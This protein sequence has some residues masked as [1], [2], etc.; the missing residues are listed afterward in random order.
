MPPFT[1]NWTMPP[2][3]CSSRCNMFPSASFPVLLDFYRSGAWNQPKQPS[4]KRRKRPSS[5]SFLMNFANDYA[6]NAR[7]SLRYALR[8]FQHKIDGCSTVFVHGCPIADALFSIILRL[9]FYAST[10]FLNILCQHYACTLSMQI[11]QPFLH[12]LPLWGLTHGSVLNS[13]IVHLK[14]MPECL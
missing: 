11:I 2:V 7:A 14:S 9:A 8:P 12:N 3:T 4:T 6:T 5:S 13:I 10:S 1:R